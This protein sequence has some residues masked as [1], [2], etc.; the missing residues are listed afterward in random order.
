MIPEVNLRFSKCLYAI[1]LV[2]LSVT[3][4]AQ[5]PTEFKNLQL[6]PSDIE[7][8]ELIDVMKNFT[9][10]LGV[11]CEFC[12]V[13]EPG[14]PLSTFDF[15]SDAK[16]NKETAREMMLMVQ[17]INSRYFNNDGSGPLHVRCV[18]CHHG[19][20]PPSTL[21]DALS[22]AMD[23]GG[24]ESAVKKYRELRGRYYGGHTFDFRERSLNNYA[25]ELASEQKVAEAIAMLELNREFHPNSAMVYFMLGE[26]H[27]QNGDKESALKNYEKGLELDP[28]NERAQKKVGSLREA[29]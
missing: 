21:Q 9:M 17:E 15:A 5:V 6:F 16:E 26:A 28:E 19:L 1:T 10:A 14:A 27:L 22:A 2:L 29:K 3:S 25:M 7:S 11:R 18:T 13:G 20:A 24:A 8:R 4:S 12:H 23:S